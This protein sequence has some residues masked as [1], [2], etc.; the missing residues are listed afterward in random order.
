MES[1]QMMELLLKK[2]SHK[3]LLAEWNAI[4]EKRD[5]N[6]KAWQE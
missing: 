4:R 6:T 3:E 5:A 2:A 1:Q